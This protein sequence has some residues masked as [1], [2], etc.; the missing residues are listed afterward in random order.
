[1]SKRKQ[2]DKDALQTIQ[3][4]ETKTSG[5]ES[6]DRKKLNVDS[7]N[8]PEKVKEEKE[9]QEVP[10]IEEQDE[11]VPE[12]EETVHVVA[13]LEYRQPVI[14]ELPNA[15]LYEISYMHR[16]DVLYCLVLKHDFLVTISV[17]G[18]LKF[19]KIIRGGIEFV[20]HYRAHLGSVDCYTNNNDMLVTCGSDKYCKVFD[21]LNFDMINM[22]QLPAEASAICLFNN[23][24]LGIA[25]KESKIDIYD[26]FG[27]KLFEIN[28]HK[29]P[30]VLM[31]F[32]PKVNICVSIDEVGNMEYWKPDSENNSHQ[33]GWTKAQTDLYEFRKNRLVPRLLNFNHD[34]SM[35]VTYELKDRLY[36]IWDFQTG[37]IIAKVDD[38]LE[39]LTKEQEDLKKLDPMEFGRRLALEKELEKSNV[40]TNAVFDE[41][42]QY[43]I[44]PTIFGIRV[45]DWRKQETMYWLGQLET[46]RFLNIGLYQG[47]PQKKFMTIEM[48]A[49]D[50]KVIRDAEE[51]D[52]A[53]YAS[54][55]KKERFYI[56]TTRE[57]NTADQDTRDIFNEKPSIQQQ[58]IAKT[59]K[60][61]LST[62]C[63]IHTSFGDISLRL[64]PEFAPK[65]VEN[66]TTL[67]KEGFYDNTIWHRCIK[68]FMIQGGDPEGIL[69]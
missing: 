35:F 25:N 17:D 28:C 12:G 40:C 15:D 51:T 33:L 44:F 64:F 48:A 9:S 3:A 53:L 6:P 45:Y 37:K 14:K 55:Y 69:D 41:T 21:I 7:N 42:G 66:F 2:D 38:S 67:G 58:S 20:K 50:N 56:L 59:E 22:I 29:S 34:H 52:P 54:A 61:A 19:W 1:M 65:A 57:P 10:E 68:G 5:S 24:L 11:E 8:G 16:D 49:S 4:G 60:V 47:S 27:G 13:I 30:V 43:L 63:T 31:A 46:I 18:H 32:N 62:S 26:C 23:N 36:R 39:F